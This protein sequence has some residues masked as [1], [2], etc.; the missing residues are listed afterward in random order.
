LVIR[1]VTNGQG[2]VAQNG[3]YGKLS[4][5]TGCTVWAL[6]QGKLH[7]THCNTVADA[8]QFP[9]GRREQE[10]AKSG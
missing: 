10:A 9:S 3:V 2:Q 5:S 1:L 6:K 8:A 7:P 4:D